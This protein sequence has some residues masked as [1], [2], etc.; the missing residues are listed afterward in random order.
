MHSAERIKHPL[1]S[2]CLQRGT[3]GLLSK[4]K[5]KPGDVMQLRVTKREGDTIY[6]N[7]QLKRQQ[8]AAA[9]GGSAGGAPSTGGAAAGGSVGHNNNPST[10]G[11]AAMPPAGMAAAAAAA[12]PR[13]AESA[14][15]SRQ[16]SKS[17]FGS[18]DEDGE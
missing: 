16:V 3:Q 18:D 14:S 8:R 1:P 13:P 4:L 7:L 11:V 6:A 2:F 10:G 9:T 15:P 5:A 12:A 17:D